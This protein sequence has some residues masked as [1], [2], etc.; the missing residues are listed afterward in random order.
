MS[1][2]HSTEVFHRSENIDNFKVE[3]KTITKKKGNSKLKCAIKAC[4]LKSLCCPCVSKGECVTLAT[5]ASGVSSIDVWAGFT[6]QVNKA[7]AGLPPQSHNDLNDAYNSY[8]K[9]LQAAAKKTIPHGIRKAYVPCWDVE[10]EDL[11]R[12]HAEA[13]ASVDR[14][15]AADDLFCRLNEKRRQR[16]TETGIN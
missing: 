5:L 14:D 3:K 4:E 12:T 6:A 16:W 13:Q 1:S 11:L 7:A 8:C 2:H 10:C 15:K 9:M